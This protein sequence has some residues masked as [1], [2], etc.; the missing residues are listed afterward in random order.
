MVTK[1]L[2]NPCYFKASKLAECVQQHDGHSEAWMIA[3][4]AYKC[5]KL[6]SLNMCSIVF[7]FL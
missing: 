4:N 2:I 3:T 7:V 1:Y 5:Y 6:D